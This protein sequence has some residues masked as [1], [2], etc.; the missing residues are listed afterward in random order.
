MKASKI[1]NSLKKGRLWVFW[2]GKEWE[3]TQLF[4]KKVLIRN[5]DG[6]MFQVH[7]NEVEFKEFIKLKHEV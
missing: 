1:K 5:R 6:E 3:V 4:T 2:R 7:V